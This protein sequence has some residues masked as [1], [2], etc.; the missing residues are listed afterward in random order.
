MYKH[1]EVVKDLEHLLAYFERK[2]NSEKIGIVARAIRYLDE[3]EYTRV[4][5]K[6]QTERARKEYMAMLNEYER[7]TWCNE[8]EHFY[9]FW[10]NG[11]MEDTFCKKLNI[12]CLST[13]GCTRGEKVHADKP[14]RRCSDCRSCVGCNRPFGDIPDNAIKD[15]GEV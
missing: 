6:R 15:K 14:K 4:D 1:E 8:C 11:Q 10:R 12:L 5:A 2:E 13:D 3:I 7:I 9:A